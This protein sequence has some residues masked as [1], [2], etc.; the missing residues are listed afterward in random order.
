M[1]LTKNFSDTVNE[2]ALSDAEYRVGLLQEG[3][4]CF[5]SG[6]YATGKVLIRDYI[7]ST[8]GF[9]DL[10]A[11][12]NKSPKSLMRMFSSQGNPTTDNFFGV[13]QHLQSQQGV[14]LQV[15]AQY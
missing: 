2:R 5:L 3:L 1:E 8:I 10:A 9:A 14:S 15:S 4:G 11:L 6:D 7:N 13:L 12:T